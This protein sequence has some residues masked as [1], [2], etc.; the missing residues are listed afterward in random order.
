MNAQEQQMI[1]SLFQ[2]L[3]QGVGR[4]GPRDAEAEALIQQHMQAMPGSGYYMAQ[5]ILMQERALQEAQQRLAAPPG[6]ASSFSGPVYGGRPAYGYAAPQ[7]GAG[8]FGGGGGGMGGF[9]GG[10]AKL[11]LGI[12]GGVL[13]GG[14]AMN[15]ANDI[16][17]HGWQGGQGGGYDQ[18]Y[19]Q[20]FQQGEERAGQGSFDPGGQQRSTYDQGVYDPGTQQQDLSFQDDESGAGFDAS[21]D[22]GDPGG[23][24]GDSGGGDSGW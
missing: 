4:A 20:G 24:W 21:D 7:P 11:A 15:V 8:L 23:G 1:E 16:F 3:A 14:V 12:G 5:P 19:D 9:M 18:G 6:G 22:A 10:A 17:G 13:L 2:R